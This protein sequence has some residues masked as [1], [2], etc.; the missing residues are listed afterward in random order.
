MLDP[1]DG[2]EAAPGEA[3]RVQWSWAERPAA[4]VADFSDPADLRPTVM[5][6]AAGTYRAQASFF[7]TTDTTG[8]T[9]LHIVEVD[10]GTDNLAPIAVVRGRG[11]PGGA[12]PL[13][14]DGSA[15]YDVNGDPLTYQW[16]IEAAPAGSVAR[17]SNTTAAMPR[18]TMDLEGR[19]LIG[20]RV[21]DAAG[22][23]SPLTTYDVEFLPRTGRTDI[24]RDS[25]DQTFLNSSGSDVHDL[26]DRSLAS[27][28]TDDFIDGF[29]L[30]TGTGAPF[31]TINVTIDGTAYQ[32]ATPQ[33]FLH[34]ADALEL[35]ASDETSAKMSS[36]PA[37]SDLTF[38]FG[39][40]AG[41]V[42]VR[43]VVGALLTRSE[44]E[45]ASVDLY[46][47]VGGRQVR[48]VASA[49]FDQL[50]GAV[51]EVVQIEPYASTDIDGN[52]L[53][54]ASNL[55][56]RPASSAAS[57]GA[58]GD[59]AVTLTP[60][61]DGDYLVSV[62]AEDGMFRSADQILI[63]V[64]AGASTRPF[65][66]IA[67]VSAIV[68]NPAKLDGTQSFDMDGDRLTYAWSVLRTPAG[69]AVALTG[70]NEAVASFTPDQA[71]L[72]IFQLQA[73]DT[74][75]VSV[76]TTLAVVVG[77]PLPVAEAGADQKAGNLG[78]VTVSGTQSSGSSLTYRWAGIG[79][80]G[81]GGTPAIASPA[82]ATTSVTLSQRSGH[83][84]DV[85]ATAPVYQFKRSDRGG[86]CEFD[87]RAPDDA[88]GSSPNQ[89]ISVS[90]ISRG[91]QSL[92]GGDIFVWEVEN[93]TTVTQ[94]VTLKDSAGVI[95]GT[96]RLPGRVAIFVTTAPIG[97]KTMNALIGA[98]S[99]AS[100]RAKN[101]PFN[102]NNPVCTGPGAA[103]MQLVVKNTAGISL[104]DTLYIGNQN[105]RPVLARPALVEAQ[106]GET[107]SLEANAVA[108]DA[109]GDALSFRWSI[110]SAPARSN[111]VISATSGA[112]VLIQ[113]DVSGRYLVQLEAHD[114][115]WNAVPVVFEI[116]VP[117]SVPVAAASLSPQT[118]FVRESVSLDGS[119]SFDP[120]GDSLTH[121]WT[122]ESRP[123]G[124]VAAI[125]DPFAPVTSFSPDKVGNY[126]FRL[127]VRDHELASAPAEVTL[128]VPN[129][130]PVASFVAPAQLFV[131]QPAIFLADGSSDP[132][133]DALSFQFSVINAPSGAN[134]DLNDL[135]GGKLEVTVD[136]SGDYEFGVIV[137]DGLATETASVVVTAKRPNQPPILSDLNPSYT[138]EV[139]LE[140]ALDLSAVDP[141]GGRVTYFASPLPLVQGMVL[142]A[143]TGRIRF[144]PE[145]SQLG[146]YQV[147][148]GASDGIFT[149]S[150]TLVL[151]VVPAN[152]GETSVYGFVLDAIDK[153][154]GVDRPLAGIPVRLQNAALQTTT[155]AN[156]QFSFGSLTAGADLLLIEPS[157]AGGPGGYAPAT[158]TITV[159]AD[160][161]RDLD[162]EFLLTP[163]NDGCTD[164][165]AGK[166]TNLTG[167]ISGVTVSIP[168]DS[169]TTTSGSAY[170]GQV[171]L[172]SLPKLFE[173][174][175]MPQDT[176]ACHIYAL[177]APGAIFTQPISLAAP[178]DDHLPETANLE[179]WQLGP[180]GT[181]F[182]KTGPASVE[183]GAANVTAEL[184]NPAPGNLFS[185]LPKAPITKVAEDQP[186]GMAQLSMFGGDLAQTYSLPGYTAFNQ[187]QSITLAYHS[188]AADPAPILAGNVTIAADS[189]LP[190]TLSSRILL[191]GLNI[192]DTVT[193][194]PRVGANGLTPPLI[195]QALTL[196]Q[197]TPLDA[198]GLASGRYKY[199]F[200]AL[201]T[202]DCSTVGASH[203]AEVYVH[204]ET[205]S[206]FGRGWAIDG[207][208]HL[209]QS[210]DGSVA[211]IDDDSTTTFDPEPTLSEFESDPLVFAN[212]GGVGLD[213]GDFDNNGLVDVA[214][215]ESGSGSIRTFLNYGNRD[216]REAQTI[217]VGTPV[218]VPQTGGYGPDVTGVAS[219]DF[220]NDGADDAAYTLQFGRGYG[221][222]LSDG[223][224]HLAK[225][226]E[227][228][229]VGDAYDVKV[230]DLDRDGYDDIIYIVNEGF[231]IFAIDRV[232]V[233]YGGPSGS[234]P[235]VIISTD[236]NGQG[237][238]SLDI[239]DIDGNGFTD[240]AYRSNRV[241]INF[242]FNEGG[243]RYQQKLPYLGEFQINL[244]GD[245]HR[246]VDANSDGQLDLVTSE[247]NQT[248]LYLNTDGRTFGPPAAIPRPPTI[249]A[250]ADVSLADVNDD[251]LVDVILS[252]SI[253]V[254]VHKNNGD[255]TFQPYETGLVNYPLH[256]LEIVDMDQDGGLD[257]VSIDRFNVRVHFSKPSTS[258][259]LVSRDGQFSKLTKQADGSWVRLYKDGSTVEF[260]ANGLQTAAVDPWGN[261]RT[262]G[263]DDNGRLATITDQV[264]GVTNFSY[265]TNGRVASITYPD[266]RTTSFEYDDA[267]QLTDVIEPTGSS[268]RYRYDDNGRLV[269]VTDQQGNTT[270]HTYTSIGTYAGS[271][272]PS[273]A[274]IRN[275]AGAA[276]GIADL[277]SA[278]QPL[279]FVQP[280]DRV[281][282]HTDEKG[283]VTKVVVNAFGA[284]VETIDPMGR[285]TLIERNEDNLAVRVSVPTGEANTNS[286]MTALAPVDSARRVDEFEYDARGNMT[287]MRM[288]VG[289]PLQ[290]ERLYRYEAIFNNLTKFTDFDG[291]VTTYAYNGFGELTSTV[292]AEGKVRNYDYNA[293]GLLQAITD[294]RGN[295]EN[296]SYNANF[297]LSFV[298]H[299]DGTVTR[300]A[301]DG[302][303]NVTERKDAEGLPEERTARTTYDFRNNPLTEEVLN[304][305]GQPIGGTLTYHYNASGNPL[306]VTDETGLRTE[307]VYD[308][309][310]RQI[311][312]ITPA[313]GRREFTYNLAGEITA[314]TDAEGATD[315][316]D[317]DIVGRVTRMED[318]VGNVSE[319]TYDLA[320]NLVSVK[321]GK[322]NVT[323]FTYDILGRRTSRTN[324]LGQTIQ[325]A[326]DVRDN[327]VEITREDG[328]VETATY[329]RLGQR[330]TVTTPDNILRFSYDEKGNLTGATDNDSA[331][332]LGYDLRDR[333]ETVSTGGGAGLQPATTLTYSYNALGQRL[334]LNDGL[335]GAWT[336]ALDGQGQVTSITAPWGEAYAMAYDP[337]GRRTSLASD[338]GRASAATYASGRLEQLEHFQNGVAIARSGFAYAP[339]G[340]IEL[341]RDLAEPA[342]SETLTYDLANRLLGVA[343]GTPIAD[344]GVPVPTEDYDYDA[345]GNRT[346]SH[347]SA[348]YLV[349]EH[350]RLLEDDTFTYSYD[351][352]GNRISRTT[353]ADGSVERY[354]YDS[355]NR[356][357][358]YANATLSARYAYDALGRRIA[359]VLDGP[360]APIDRPPLDPLALKLTAQAG[361]DIPDLTL[362][363][364]FTIEGWVRLDPGIDNR[365]GLLRSDPSQPVQDLNFYAG[366]LRLYSPGSGAV[367]K[368]VAATPVAANVW[369]HYAVTR[370]ADGTMKLYVN[371]VLDATAGAFTA[372]FNVGLLGQTA[373]GVTAGQFDDI[374]IWT[375]ERTAAEIAN[376]R[377]AYVT[378]GT[379]GLLRLYRFD[380]D[381][382]AVTDRAGTSAAA[383]LAAGTSLVASTA[384]VAPDPTPL[385]PPGPGAEITAYVY[386]IGAMY[387][388]TGHDR[389]LEYR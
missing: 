48:P 127:V 374:R 80:T 70:S 25:Y 224:G 68:G 169:I 334:S 356:L 309:M 184:S 133:G 112:S 386:D 290:R 148:V 232:K 129:R 72:Y 86:L 29:D 93:K 360:G 208:Q 358:G 175:A 349:D 298:Q 288:A 297:N 45:A 187:D 109:D 371:G 157:A 382:T 54:P 307:F 111:A 215:T 176:K 365:D 348:I 311:A 203:K 40:D 364:A 135:G 128:T 152:A 87:T 260:D 353:K 205:Q 52:R 100:D 151:N 233:S 194:N 315:S 183:Q 294:E 185:F 296:R 34:L 229:N 23:T 320:N 363:G 272:F 317:Y 66:R 210:P 350:N 88:A 222:L 314:E 174:E 318:A 180:A 258:G 171:C 336:Y 99:Y 322:G 95:H 69:S 8:L 308:P 245:F 83:F 113:T 36:D 366:R 250:S 319:F 312:E 270:E 84:R 295:T 275:E 64:G 149:D 191:G 373:A 376:A 276:V 81:D 302:R 220:N 1:T 138:V 124:S 17:I 273:G 39:G 120:D 65:A 238:V 193:W 61:V 279:A 299:P 293:V 77:A 266:G 37:S 354:V 283:G 333:L 261:R 89:G 271:L 121:E 254:Q 240:I 76:P 345:T 237:P 246:L 141:D 147:T 301:Y 160:Q 339:D 12:T 218:S 74:T 188:V 62:T 33:S 142:D 101:N 244:K 381:T 274:T 10:F 337:A 325:M 9:P 372:P 24:Y 27:V 103:V 3:L 6:D 44:L 107:V 134:P 286:Q 202:Y 53:I 125:A 383:P 32:L 4:S 96:W 306:G 331:L 263:Y 198:T 384:T 324:P 63:S 332:A 98:T 379:A 287:A 234:S 277:N 236:S 255:G 228:L 242:V 201:A 158:R 182:H 204:N 289:T 46:E 104:P 110:L 56:I 166:D 153:A 178:N 346:A 388:V 2:F 259:V 136:Q 106:R 140:L 167:T 172:G 43:G 20:L 368:I 105:L 213:T 73:S 14:L 375:V 206:L 13:Q 131:G 49:R 225:A 102:R 268:V 223:N 58:A 251:G 281:S 282:Y 241:G 227:T 269:A 139:G 329:D 370:A 143:A 78:S 278:P 132:D 75:Q 92:Q 216:V 7:A 249:T 209:A 91:R 292:D 82:A 85:I 145:A 335:G 16:T 67:P 385:P 212:D 154:N 362:T 303:G 190:V 168:A 71:G 173:H 235:P 126:T 389:L 239:G 123:A 94:S 264:G 114:A 117:N 377:S 305:S 170:D 321:D 328:T 221:Y 179:L 243:R 361:I 380:G 15:S 60:D 355:Q 265:D 326:Y 59:G 189:S 369:T 122:I 199:A 211:I 197:S 115:V 214:V 156:G 217:E 31:D 231:W 150:Q 21:Q 310:N 177:D 257:L 192:T 359:K 47:G 5:L 344:G 28:A 248:Y 357:I 327:L 330:L 42:T 313:A 252:D 247:P 291:A 137:S 262:Y 50:K 130:A 55:L 116:F 285:Q 165:V 118:V 38:I 161:R 253:G 351:A 108:S 144:R 181:A 340:Q 162:P 367:D 196:R 26:G 90:L 304:A 280:E 30:D 347:L 343:E 35:D 300:F 323:L 195:G 159:T 155:D 219:G 119:G 186:Q 79:L 207:L 316:Y 51:G 267:A 11:L 342:Q 378:P 387:D 97:N 200:S 57:L 164:V 18:L 226:F 284:I 41:S 338:D 341:L 146:T 230:T 256:S 19:Y 352:K 163:L 22:L